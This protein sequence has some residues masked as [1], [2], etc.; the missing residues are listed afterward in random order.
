MG[1]RHIIC[2]SAAF[3]CVLAHAS[4]VTLQDGNT[5]VWRGEIDD[6]ANAAF[7]T[8]AQSP[9]VIQVLFIDSNGGTRSAVDSVIR[10]IE[11][12]SFS[13]A[14][15]GNCLSACALAFL[16]G[17]SRTTLLSDSKTPTTVGIHGFYNGATKTL[18]EPKPSEVAYIVER[19]QGRISKELAAQALSIHS[20]RGGL[21]LFSSPVPTSDG[22][23]SAAV[24]D[25]NG[26]DEKMSCRS[27]LGDLHSYGIVTR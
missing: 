18:V 4:A 13:T 25:T 27:I 14:V 19:T 15:Q 23:T 20:I 12:R 2:L 16:A 11:K 3:A 5:I 26:I 22:P 6:A 7:Q 9:E 8:L 10:T 17:T 21:L 1:R 24:C